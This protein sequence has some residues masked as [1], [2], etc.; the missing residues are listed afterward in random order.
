MTEFI[1]LFF[2]QYL[3]IFVGI[4]LVGL[5]CF[6]LYYS[7]KDKIKKLFGINHDDKINKNLEDKSLISNRII[8]LKYELYSH[9][10]DKDLKRNTDLIEISNGWG[11]ASEH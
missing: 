4:V 1:N 8:R 11:D 5:I 7:Y 3:R 9:K 2:N 10:R 6:S